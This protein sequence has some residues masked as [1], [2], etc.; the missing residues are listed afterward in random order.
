ML[1]F[2]N[3]FFNFLLS[4]TERGAVDNMTLSDVVSE[5]NE[6]H[7]VSL[8]ARTSFIADYEI[9]DTFITGM[10]HPWPQKALEVLK[11]LQHS[12]DV[13]L[14]RC[15]YMW[16]CWVSSRAKPLHPFFNR[17]QDL[18]DAV[19]AYAD[20]CSYGRTTMERFRMRMEMHRVLAEALRKDGLSTILP[21]SKAEGEGSFPY[22]QA[23]ECTHLNEA[24]VNWVGG[25]LNA[26]AVELGEKVLEEAE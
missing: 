8:D 2:K 16:L 1:N 4:Q 23:H 14:W 19:D 20:H 3:T 22:E 13:E 25:W 5:F 26:T 6:R 12:P 18:H 11:P 17:R 9:K 21:F 10:A 24:R 15:L 7:G